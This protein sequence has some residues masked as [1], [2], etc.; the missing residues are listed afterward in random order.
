MANHETNVDPWV[1][2]RLA[3]LAEPEQ[4]TPN[5]A[6]A[7]AGLRERIRAPKRSR[8]R[9]LLWAVPL[10]LATLAVFL[11][12]ATRACAQRPG[13]CAQSLWTA[14]AQP[15]SAPVTLEIYIDYQCPPC[16][17][18][19]SNVLPLLEAQYVKT[20]KL[21]LVFHDFPLPNHRY[22]KLAARYVNAA[23][24]LGYL[25]VA[26]DQVFRT[27][28]AWSV[29]GDVD[30]ELAPALLPDV[31]RQV[32]RLVGED[33]HFDDAVEA[34][35]AA[36]RADGIKQTPSVVLVYQGKRQIVP[37]KLSFDELKAR[38]DEVLGQTNK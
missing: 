17:V 15:V 28:N 19:S 21:K 37:G 12:P 23:G 34:G 26:M 31:M 14:V 7:A 33:A 2:E 10:S 3:A 29:T 35:I 11:L 16:A 6:R 24:Q 22:A 36:G 27:R 5:T 4:W 8:P 25:R 20:G 1:D 30:S 13:A 38:L 9:W 32:R 18:F